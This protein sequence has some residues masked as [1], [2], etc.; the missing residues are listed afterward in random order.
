MGQIRIS[1][2]FCGISDDL[3]ADHMMI[4][5][6]F[7]TYERVYIPG[8][9][10]PPDPRVS[11]MIDR[12]KLDAKEDHDVLGEWGNRDLQVDSIF[13]RTETALIGFRENKHASDILSYFGCVDLDLVYIC[14]VGGA[15]FYCDGYHF[16][17]HPNEDIHKYHPHVHVRR[18]DEE[19]RYSLDTLTRF[20]SDTFSHTF[21]KD[22][23]K[24]ILPYLKKNQ[25][26]LRKQWDMYMNGYISPME[27]EEG[28]QYYR[29]QV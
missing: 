29:Y 2:L 3:L 12:F 10:L 16:I 28:R 25:A 7:E 18:D 23:K 15:S 26:K 9:D 20:P 22:E 11:E 24:H 4:W 13:L 14:L 8:K 6:P 1:A 5:K 19:T 17:V 21:K 27:D